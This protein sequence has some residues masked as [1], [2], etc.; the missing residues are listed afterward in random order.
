[1]WGT[2]RSTKLLVSSLAVLLESEL[3]D[4][5]ALSDFISE[6]PLEEQND[7]TD[8]FSPLKLKSTANAIYQLSLDV[9][10]TFG[11]MLQWKSKLL[12]FGAQNSLVWFGTISTA[13][14]YRDSQSVSQSVSLFISF[15]INQPAKP[16]SA[17]SQASQLELVPREER[18]LISVTRNTS[19]QSRASTTTTT[20]SVV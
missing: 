4:S 17:A 14:D 8:I 19:E 6:D 12:C 20:T 16:A 1:M 7:L 5:T 13:A 9:S 10:H 2:S 11:A 15:V 18:A 3:S